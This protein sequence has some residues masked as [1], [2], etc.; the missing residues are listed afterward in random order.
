MPPTV[1]SVT[2]KGLSGVEALFNTLPIALVFSFILTTSSPSVKS[3]TGLTVIVKV[4][5]SVSP[6]PSSTV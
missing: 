4:D 1:K 6:A 3:L 5:I 2:D